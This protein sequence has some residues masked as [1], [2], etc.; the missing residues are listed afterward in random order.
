MPS[1][2]RPALGSIN[3]GRL[4][5][6]KILLV[7]TLTTVYLVRSRRSCVTFVVCSGMAFQACGLISMNRGHELLNGNMQAASR[8]AFFVAL[9]AIRLF[10]GPAGHGRDK[11]KQSKQSDNYTIDVDRQAL[12]HTYGIRMLTL[13]C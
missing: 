11:D 2:T 6:M 8:T 7:M 10:I 4:C 13:K 3:A 9:D 5:A 12:F 1:M